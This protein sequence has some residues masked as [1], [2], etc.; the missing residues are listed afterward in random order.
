MGHRSQYKTWNYKTIEED[1]GENICNLESGKDLLAVI[2]KLDFIKNLK[3]L[4]F[5]SHCYENEKISHRVG[6]NIWTTH[7]WQMTSIQNT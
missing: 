1:I 7:I 6:E 5:K 3:L 4:L 2:N